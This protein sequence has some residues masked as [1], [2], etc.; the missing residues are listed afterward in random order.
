VNRRAGLIALVAAAALGLASLLAVRSGWA[1]YLWD[2][3]AYGSSIQASGRCLDLP[4]QWTVVPGGRNGVA[5]VR[6]HFAGSGPE[7]LAS[8][9]PAKLVAGAQHMGSGPASVGGGFVM[10][11]LGSALPSGSLRYIAIDESNATA[12]M[13]GRSELLRELA[14]GLST[15]RQ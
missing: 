8:I 15:C 1:N 3:Y 11:D 5:D 6:R 13:A 14:T 9:L 4:R 10:Y 12:L 2:R 7:V